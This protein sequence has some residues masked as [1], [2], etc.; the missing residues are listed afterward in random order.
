ML[1]ACSC[2]RS[3][4]GS[5]HANVLDDDTVSVTADAADAAAIYT[6][7]YIV[8]SQMPMLL[9]CGGSF[10]YRR[11]CLSNINIDMLDRPRRLIPMIPIT[12]ILKYVRI[13]CRSV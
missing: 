1:T 6:Y 13:Y 5:E 3:C 10:V 7:I 2:H 4:H 9:S 12:S 8:M 11:V